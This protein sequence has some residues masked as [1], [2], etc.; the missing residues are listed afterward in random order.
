MQ[1]NT[2]SALENVA[3]KYLRPVLYYLIHLVQILS[4]ALH[5]D[6]TMLCRIPTALPT[7]DRDFKFAEMFPF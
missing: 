2:E 4:K 1:N 6:L 7:F 3:P 5:S